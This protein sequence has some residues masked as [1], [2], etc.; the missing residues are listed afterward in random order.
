MGKVRGVAFGA[1]LSA[2]LLFLPCQGHA[3]DQDTAS[4]DWLVTLGVSVH[5][6]PQYP[7]ARTLIIA[8]IP[9]IDLRHVGD[10]IRFQAPDQSTSLGVLGHRSGFDFGPAGTIRLKRDEDDVGAPVGDVGFTVE[11]G[12]FVR[13]WV[14]PHL[15]LRAEGRKGIGGHHGLVGDLSAD[16]VLR[17]DDRTIFSI[18][19]RLHFADEAFENAYFG[20]S[21]AASART[22]IPVYRPGGGLYGA[23]AVA[24]VF[25]QLSPAWGVN[26]YAGYNR[27]VGGAADSPI[28]RRFG[29]R[30]QLSA[31][32]GLTYTFAYHRH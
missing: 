21:P 5:A 7:G 25:H 8:P 15:R 30:D 32:L 24:G 2:V 26:A 23:G 11:A 27:L 17:D 12:A 29:S 4:R 1:G 3:Q 13:T 6:S 18:G 14:G 20:I 28:V 19:P 31:G 9:S 10:P 22:G 16:F